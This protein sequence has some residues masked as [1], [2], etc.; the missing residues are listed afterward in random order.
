M[1]TM[2]ATIPTGWRI[3][4]QVTP[5]VPD[6]TRP[7]MFRAESDDVAVLVISEGGF[8][9][10][11]DDRQYAAGRGGI[12]FCTSWPDAMNYSIKRNGGSHAFA[13]KMPPDIAEV[14]ITVDN[15]LDVSRASVARDTLFHGVRSGRHLS[16]E[17]VV[18]RQGRD[19]FK[20]DSLVLLR[21]C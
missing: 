6:D 12:Y 7:W 19:V 9:F 10:P 1:A 21:R 5:S 2:A 17:V 15:A 8:R 3:E 11:P 18:A 13:C 14:E 4:V 20:P 16:S